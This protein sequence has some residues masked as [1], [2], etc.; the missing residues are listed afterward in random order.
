[1]VADRHNDEATVVVIQDRGQ[2]EG[3]APESSVSVKDPVTTDVE[4]LENTH[5]NAKPYDIPVASDGHDQHPAATEDPALPVPTATLKP[6]RHDEPHTLNAEEAPDTGITAVTVEQ[7]VGPSAPTQE[8]LFSRWSPA[9]LEMRQQIEQFSEGRFQRLSNL[10]PVRHLVHTLKPIFI[11][12][13]S[14]GE[15]P[16]VV[17]LRRIGVR[18]IMSCASFSPADF[19]SA[20]G[21]LGPLETT[22]YYPTGNPQTHRIFAF[23]TAMDCLDDL[24]VYIRGNDHTRITS[25]LPELAQALSDL[26]LHGHALTTCQFALEILEG[27][28]TAAPDTSRLKV[29]SVLSLQASILCDLKRKD[30]S[31]D[32]ANNAVALFKEHRDCEG[33]PVPEVDYALLNYAVLLCSFGLMDEGA[34]VAFELQ[35]E[36][37]VDSRPDMKHVSS[38]CRLCLSITRIGD[39]DDTA[40]SAADE[41]IE[42]SRTSSDVDT[43]IVL[44][45]ALLTKSKILSSKG[46]DGAAWPVSAEATTLLRTIRVK[47]PVFSLI[48]AHAL[49]I[50]SHHLM[51][52][53]RGAESFSTA[54]DAVE[55]WQTLRT[56]SPGP[57]KQRLARSLLHLARFRQTDGNRNILNEELRTAE[58]AVAVFREVSPLDAPG[59]GDALYL[60]ADRMLELDKNR[61]AATYAEES[62]HY[63]REARLEEPG[64]EKYAFDLVVSLSL[65]SSCL[66]CTERAGD[67]LEYAKQAVEVQ[68][69]RQG[70]ADG[71]HGIHL[72]KLLMDVIFR[73]TEMDKR[74]DAHPWFEELQRLG[75]PTGM[76]EY[77]LWPIYPII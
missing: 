24:Q 25:K 68:H 57:T 33:A 19:A 30:D 61:D 46:Q 8:S 74:E 67:A 12:L 17:S 45:G 35:C 6:Y 42:L 14:Q 2:Q 55:L 27:P 52:V 20:I 50:H 58:T 23:T 76:G 60:Y 15:S 4:P 21:Y 16:D 59:L 75:P 77:S 44:A 38:L 36:V 28:Y 47:R 69:E 40:L 56:S 10:N 41:T 29:A 34:A 64:K 7:D 70:T 32:A 37:D 54:R 11:F 3:S 26:G 31:I 65:A 73:S 39:D 1:M 9:L 48:L 62:V 22:L 71:Q 53:D 72:R 13:I 5:N 49:D 18:L 43:Q 51:K 63:F 66:A